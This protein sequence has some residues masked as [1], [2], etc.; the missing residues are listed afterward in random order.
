MKHSF[1]TSFAEYFGVQEYFVWKV[2][3][4][5][6]LVCRMPQDDA[7]SI[8][9]KFAGHLG[10]ILNLYLKPL[11]GNICDIEVFG[12]VL[13]HYFS[14]LNSLD[15]FVQ[16]PLRLIL[17]KILGVENTVNNVFSLMLSTF[18][19]LYGIKQFHYPQLVK[20]SLTC[21]FSETGLFLRVIITIPFKS[22]E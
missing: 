4:W 21:N 8:P 3:E 5:L 20:S 13:S 19:F 1:I 9:I 12:G 17:L 10:S 14:G 18:K 11:R 16:P 6:Q 22:F 7:K 2:F 15:I